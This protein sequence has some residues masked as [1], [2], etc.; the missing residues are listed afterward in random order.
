LEALE[1]REGL[2]PGS[3]DIMPI[4]TESA[5]AALSLPELARTTLPRMAAISWGAEDLGAD[6]GASA[7]RDA[8]GDWTFTYEWLR[9]LTLLAAKAAGSCAIDTIHADFSDSIG[10]AASCAR[11]ASDGFTGKLAIHP[12][13]VDIINKGFSPSAAALEQALKVVEAFDAMPGAGAVAVDGRM[14]DKPHLTLARRVLA[15]ARKSGG[16]S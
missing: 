6:L 14:V 3:T 8:A 11:A 15:A 2:P 12:A 9:S 16:A 13:Q 4:A 1:V 7:T 5:R 10:L